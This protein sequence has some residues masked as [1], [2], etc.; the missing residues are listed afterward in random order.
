LRVACSGGLDSSVLLHALAASAEAR[1]RGLAAI[2]VDHGLAADSAAWAEHCRRLAAELDI[3]IEVRRVRVDRDSSLGLEAA[4]RAARH[5]VYAELLPPGGVL[6]TAHHQDDQAETVLMRL[7]R[8]AGV[9]GLAAMRPLRRYAQGWLARP[10]LDIDRATLAACARAAGI[11]AIDDPANADPTHDRSFVRHRVVP[12]LRE[13][14]AHATAGIADSAA[15][16]AA[17]AAVQAGE[18]ERRLAAWLG[19]DPRVLSTAALAGLDYATRGALLRH[20]CLAQPCAPPDAAALAGIA[21]ALRV[22]RRDAET[23]V[24]WADVALHVWRDALW[25]EF[26]VV[27]P[28]SGWECRWDG[29]DRIVLPGGAGTLCMEGPAPA[30]ALDLV[31]RP[32][33]GGERIATGAG[34]PRRRVKHLLQELAIPPWRRAI[35]PCVWSGDTVLAVG[36]WLLDPG[37]AATLAA[38][39][40]C[41]R[42]TPD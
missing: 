26:P 22:T 39:D 18:L 13:R 11:R 20:W 32:R 36:D 29:R 30:P 34:R 15:H 6:V 10:L 41:L 4:A 5:A 28:S 12:L 19:P 37:F 17:S 2:H 27:Q 16:L 3:E 24:R 23:R 9:E 25:I 42:W 35:A 31:V 1:A 7:V 40:V 38:A 14:W 8:G 33:V 21:A